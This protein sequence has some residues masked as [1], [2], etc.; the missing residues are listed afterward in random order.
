M[1]D[2]KNKDQV[3][4]VLNKI[5]E[6]EL[7]GVVRYLH[8]ALTVRGP[9][10]IPIVQFFDSQ[11]KESLLHATTI[12]TKIVSYGGHP[13]LKQ[14]SIPETVSHDVF[15]L[16]KESLQF[17]RQA[18]KLYRELLSLAGDDIALEEMART[19]IRTEMEDVEEVEKMLGP[20]D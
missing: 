9:N 11:S 12:G 17:E 13:P 15:D 6:A 7:A 1:S 8:Y 4:A 20:K 16:L 5:Y 14:A 18:I 2:I 10:R 3:L 19:M